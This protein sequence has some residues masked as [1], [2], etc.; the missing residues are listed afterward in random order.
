MSAAADR[1]VALLD[2]VQQ[3]D[4]PRSTSEL[5]MALPKEEM[6]WEGRCS[7]PAM[8]DSA[9]RARYGYELVSCNHGRQVVRMPP[10]QTT[11]Y[12][13]L[14]DLEARGMIR[15]MF[16]PESRIVFWEAISIETDQDREALEKIWSLS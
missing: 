15:R 7:Q 1:R 4:H 11:V 14:R 10:A 3:S 6:T 16:F 2:L 5:R 9:Y 8:H 12:A 13:T